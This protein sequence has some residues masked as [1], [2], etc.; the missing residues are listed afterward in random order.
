MPKAPGRKP[1]PSEE[2]IED[3]TSHALAN[4]FKTNREL[5]EYLETIGCPSVSQNTVSKYLRQ[6]GIRCRI[7]AEKPLLSTEAKDYRVEAALSNLLVPVNVFRKTVFLDE[8]SIDS[9]MK[10]KT[11]VKRTKGQRYSANNINHYELRNPK[12]L[13]FVCCFSYNG[14]GP[15]QLIEGRLNAAKYLEFLSEVVITVYSEIFDEFYLLHDNSRVHTARIVREYLAEMLPNRVHL[16]PAYSPDLNPIENLGHFLKKK[17]YD[18]LKDLSF[19]DHNRLNQLICEIWNEFNSDLTLIHRLVDSMHS[20]Y[21][22]C[23]NSMGEP[24]RY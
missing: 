9:R 6:K 21:R 4:N 7:A 10:R 11:R 1:K 17:L 2:A 12:S 8:F 20:R 13:S 18:R 3:L 16:H 15:I 19:H 24:T 14:T 22:E 5:A 23:I